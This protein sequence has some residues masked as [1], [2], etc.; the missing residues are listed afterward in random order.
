MRG[1]IFSW[2]L[3]HKKL[4]LWLL[5]DLTALAAFFL[6]RGNRAWMNALAEHVTGPLRQALGRLCYRTEISV[7]E[8]LGVLVVLAAVG[9]AV[10][11][12]AA[13]FRARGYRGDRAYSA[14]LGAACVGLMVYAGFCLL[15]GVNFWTDS[16]QDRSGIYAQPVA[17]EDLTAV[18]KYF[19]AQTAEAA[20]RV[21][22]DENGLFAVSREE[23]L[24]DSTEVYE[25]LEKQYP[26]LEFDDPG[27]KAMAFSRLMSWMDFTGFYCPWTGESNVNVDSPACLLAATVAHELAHQR[28]IASEQECN[29]LAVLASTTSDLP[30]YQHAGWLS[31]YIYLGNALYRQDP[32]TYWAI[33]DAMP[34]E[35]KADLAYNNAYWAQFRDSVVQTVSNQVYDGLLKAYGDE[36]GIQSYGTV[37]DLLVV[38]YREEA[39]LTAAGGT[40]EESAVVK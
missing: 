2:F 39:E 17:L 15:W 12:A 21:S 6:T 37:V 7:M 4:H 22:R 29:F 25:N 8:V 5:A 38:Y 35:V 32:D 23:I 14:L 19:A 1:R 11:N 13:V 20:D 10:W 3:R 34:D 28:G 30:A 24:A 31:G 26:F 18:T 36:R 40:A 16:F 9:Y 27:V 33:R